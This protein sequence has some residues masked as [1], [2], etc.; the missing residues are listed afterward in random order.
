M[1]LKRPAQ[2]LVFCFS[3]VSALCGAVAG[4]YEVL[5]WVRASLCLYRGKYYLAVF[6]S[7]KHRET[8]RKTAGLSGDYLG[9]AQVLYAYFEEHGTPISQNAVAQLGGALKREGF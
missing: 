7:L 1:K 3:G 4:L 8:V 6:S 5:P 2:P 9:A